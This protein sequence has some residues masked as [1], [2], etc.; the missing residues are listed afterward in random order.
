MG[1]LTF[2]FMGGDGQTLSGRLEL[3]LGPVRAYALFAH[4][5][6]CSKDTHAARHIA[7]GLSDAGIAVLRFD[8]TGLGESDG[9]FGHAGMTGDVA[10]LLAAARAMELAQMAPSLLIGHSLGGAAILAAAGHLPRVKAV[11]TIGAPFDPGHVKGLFG[12]ALPTLMANGEAEVELAGRQL[13]FRKSYL[14]GLAHPAQAEKIRNLK[15]ALLILH[16]PRDPVVG[17]D[18]AE[19]IWL[20]ARHPKSFITLDDADHML[21]GEGDAEY[22]ACVIAAWAARYLPPSISS[23]DSRDLPAVAEPTEDGLLQTRLTTGGREIIVDEPVSIGGRGQGP[24]P[25]GLLTAAL[26]ACTTMTLRMYAQRKGWIVPSVRVEVTHAKGPVG[27]TPRD[28]FTRR[29]WLLDPIDDER[30]NALIEAAD[31]C[32]VHLT[33]E[34]SSRVLTQDADRP[35]FDESGAGKAIITT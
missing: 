8:F 18:N 25:Y 24:T 5:F 19:A 15:R 7:R 34:A 31:R 28:V 29:I 22:A 13:R 9:E 23:A 32:P 1:T 21:R 10:D 33:L 14:D 26:A 2:D 27:S 4:C 11:A 16:A 6:T 30:R 17:I 35:G 12:A 20:A 3:P